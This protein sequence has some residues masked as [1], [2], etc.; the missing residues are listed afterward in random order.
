MGIVKPHNPL[1]VVIVQRQVVAD[2][3]W[4]VLR[5]LYHPCFNFVPLAVFFRVLRAIQI[6]QNIKS[7]IVCH[8][9]FFIIIR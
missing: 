8:T 3:V 2:T 1:V 6:Q 7:I 9:I 5:W 4:D